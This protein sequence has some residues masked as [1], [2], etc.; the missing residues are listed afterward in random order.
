MSI[1][2]K[3]LNP[4]SIRLGKNYNVIMEDK[5]N[6]E[7]VPLTP[8]AVF[9]GERYGFILITEH[10]GQQKEFVYP[11][12]CE[13]RAIA[14]EE[15]TLII[16]EDGKKQPWRFDKIGNLKYSA[17]DDFT[18]EFRINSNL[19]DEECGLAMDTPALINPLKIIISKDPSKSFI[20]IEDDIKEDYPLYPGVIFGRDVH[21]GF[22]LII[23]TDKGQKELVYPTCNVIDSIGAE[24]GAYVDFKVFEKGKRH[25]WLFGYDGNLKKEACNNLNDTN[26]ES[27]YIT[28]KKK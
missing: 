22:I 5:S 16:F 17:I 24:E 12:Q 20:L 15:G 11:T 2:A 28:Q 4:I 26:A 27:S 21:Y 18:A 25:P 1:E 3:I 6:K 14:I 13:I 9:G 7:E 8:G 10:N 23:G 19:I